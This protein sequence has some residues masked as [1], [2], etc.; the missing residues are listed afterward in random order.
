M[1]APPL[2]REYL[3]SCLGEVDFP[4]QIIKED[5]LDMIALADVI[6]VASGTATLM[7]GLM[8]KPMVILYKMNAVTAWVARRL[9]TKTPFFG[10]V[11]LIMN[12]QIVP[13][14]FQEQANPE[15]LAEETRRFLNDV[16]LREQTVIHLREM[17][18]RL[19]SRGATA[20]VAKIVDRYFS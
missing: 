16:K 15:R 9:V 6:L 4:I 11:N 10:M 14:L 12:R 1:V 18:E 2:S 17:K 8:E 19:G 7:V 13:E 20:R 5:P 3:K